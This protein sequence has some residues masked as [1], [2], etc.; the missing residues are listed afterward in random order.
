[1]NIFPPNSMVE[2]PITVVGAGAVGDAVA[3]SLSQRLE[4][5]FV[6]EKNGGVAGENQSSKSSCVSHAG[7]YYKTG[8]LRAKLCV[9]GNKLLEEFCRQHQVPYKQTGKLLVA[10]ER[11]QREYIQHTFETAKANNVP[12]VR[13]LTEAEAKVF[14]PNIRCSEGALY[15]PTSGILEPTSLVKAY[16]RLAIENDAMFLYGTTVVNIEPKGSGFV[17]H[18]RSNGREE[19][20]ETKILINAAGLYSADIARLVNPESPYGIRVARG[21][22]AKFLRTRRPELQV[23]MNVYPAPYAT[24]NDTGEVAKVPLAKARELI[25][26]GVATYTVGVHLTPTLGAADGTYFDTAGDSVIS[27]IVTIGPAKTGAVDRED[28]NSVRKPEY[29]Y[30]RVHTFFPGLRLE[31]IELHQVGNMANP[32]GQEDWIIERDRKYPNCVHLIGINS[33]GLTGSLAIGKYVTQLL[34]SR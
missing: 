17:V 27:T 25:A 6:L 22:A 19:S 28:Y 2:V 12:G 18:T 26:Q 23:G 13:L 29:Y 4:G 30:D 7:I 33:P 3:Y 16:E 20:F 11:W 32:V 9:E 15:V 14:E 1:V 21:E 24:Y 8:S 34:L 5:I 31:D 10:V